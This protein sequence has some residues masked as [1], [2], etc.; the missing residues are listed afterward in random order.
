VCYLRSRVILAFVVHGSKR[1][2]YNI[3]LNERSDS[4]QRGIFAGV[5]NE[6][7]KRPAL[8]SLSAFVAVF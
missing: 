3:Y 7:Y 4:Q 6:I 8:N 2:T 5:T 1:L